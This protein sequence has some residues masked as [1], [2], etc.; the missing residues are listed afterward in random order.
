MSHAPAALRD[1]L[2]SLRFWAEAFREHTRLHGDPRMAALANR[3]AGARAEAAA[4]C[5]RFTARSAVV[6]TPAEAGGDFWGL[7]VL[8]RSRASGVTQAA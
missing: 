8:R 7:R 5:L 1:E 6:E 3:F 4:V 2:E